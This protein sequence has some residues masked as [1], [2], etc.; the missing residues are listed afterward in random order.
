MLLFPFGLSSCQGWDSV[1]VSHRFLQ[2]V[3]EVLSPTF[4]LIPS[5]SLGA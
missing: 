5:D 2:V 3:S 1:S 4:P